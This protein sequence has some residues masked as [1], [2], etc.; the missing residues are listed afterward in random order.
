MSCTCQICGK[1]YKVVLIIP[2]GLWKLI[3]PQG[4][5]DGLMCGSCIMESFEIIGL[6]QSFNLIPTPQNDEK[7]EIFNHYM[8]KVEESYIK[9]REFDCDTCIYYERACTHIPKHSTYPCP[10][11]TRRAGKSEPE[12]IQGKYKEK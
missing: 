5:T 12:K 10:Y 4:Q 8:G 9:E 2:D 11:W 6:Y 1:Q 7:Q 3:K